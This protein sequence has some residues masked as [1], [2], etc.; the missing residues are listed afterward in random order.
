MMRSST[1]CRTYN[2]FTTTLNKVHIAWHIAWQPTV[3]KMENLLAT[4]RGTPREVSSADDYL[5]R[6]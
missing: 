1:V 2:R 3:R 5:I 4:G 6:N